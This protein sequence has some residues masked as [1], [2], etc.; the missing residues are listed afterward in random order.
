MMFHAYAPTDAD[1]EV[2]SSSF[3]GG[4][5]LEGLGRELRWLSLEA[6]SVLF[7]IGD[8]ALH[9]YI[10]VRGCLD[11]VVPEMD[12][13]ERVIEQIGRQES[14]G[15]MALLSGEPRSATVRARR[16]SVLV[17]VPREAFLSMLARYPE[18]HLALT[19]Q[20]VHR[21]RNTSH[22]QRKAIAEVVAI[23]PV[24]EEDGC[25][26]FIARLESALASSGRVV[27]LDYGTA[28]R[29][30]AG[31]A[32]SGLSAWLDENEHQRRW[33]LL[34]GAVGQPAWNELCARF[35]ERHLLVAPAAARPRPVTVSAAGKRREAVLLHSKGL[36]PSNGPAWQETLGAEFLHHVRLEKE[37]ADI[38]R[39]TRFLTGAANALILSGGAMKGVA[40]IGVIRAIEEARLPVD[41]VCGAS[42]GAFFAGLL[43]LELSWR[44]IYA[45]ARDLII[46]RWPLK[47]TV[48]VLS[49]TNDTRLKRSLAR[50]F[51][52]QAIED[53]PRAFFCVSSSLSRAALVVHRS[54]PLWEAVLAS[55]AVPGLLPPVQRGDDL[56]V[57]GGL[58]N[59]LPV[60]MVDPIAR[61]RKIAVNV[62][63]GP[64]DES[65]KVRSPM[66]ASW[67]RLLLQRLNPFGAA[68]P[69]LLFD[70]LVR[71]AALGSF[72]AVKNASTAVDLY[73][74]PEVTKLGLL[75]RSQFDRMV[76]LGYEGGQR[77]LQQWPFRC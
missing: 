11:V 42:S 9:G 46:E 4:V 35:A 70:I 1:R 66:N 43:A 55:S 68:R 33:I 6:G 32:A 48:P 27:R 15:E 31:S 64:L 39:L 36:A 2:I 49:F 67:A 62:A 77:A 44:E 59:N 76:E 26:R 29:F 5:A 25:A 30:G 61:C 69:P 50:L 63:A 12:G 13:H 57:D 58:L 72:H 52:E 16:D 21:L 10:V 19:K 22:Q 75:D 45:R 41:L 71:T 73:I 8:E 20:L 40:H 51:D 7:S 60:E 17:E 3:F 24:T 53:L 74:E 14:V 56:L 65:M 38:A 28:A 37:E 47:M 34:E 18:V 23:L 54:G